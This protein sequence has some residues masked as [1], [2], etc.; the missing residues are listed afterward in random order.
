MSTLQSE[1]THLPAYCRFKDLRDNGIVPNWQQLR[2]LVEDEDFP[3]G[4]LLSRHR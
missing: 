3:P 1:E 2:R 4:L